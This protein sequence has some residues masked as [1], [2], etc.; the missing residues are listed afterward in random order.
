MSASE[1]YIEHPDLPGQKV[2]IPRP[3]LGQYMQQLWRLSKDQS[4]PVDPDAAAAL[5]AAAENAENREGSHDDAADPG[6]DEHETPGD[7]VAPV[8]NDDDPEES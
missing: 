4:D 5:A 8:S 3:A 6:D 1:V 2:K 7:A